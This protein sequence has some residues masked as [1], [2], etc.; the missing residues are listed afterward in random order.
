MNVL[1]EIQS[2]DLNDIGR[3][4]FVFRSAA[5]ALAAIVATSAGIYMFVFEDK[6]P[7]LE[8]SESE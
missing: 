3:W 1:E 8:K 2:L 6:L 7:L 4:P 5:V